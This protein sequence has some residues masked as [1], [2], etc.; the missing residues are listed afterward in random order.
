M[1]TLISA[2]LGLSIAFLAGC[3]GDPETTKQD[4]VEPTLAE[5]L[6]LEPGVWFKVELPGTVCAN[7]S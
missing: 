1:R 2:C 4:P 3:G 7:G 6:G 5:Q